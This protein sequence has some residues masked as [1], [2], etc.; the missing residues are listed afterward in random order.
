VSLL[1]PQAG[2]RDGLDD[3]DH[4]RVGAETLREHGKAIL[5]DA[6]T[7]ATG[8]P[9]DDVRVVAE[10]EG[11]VHRNRMRTAAAAS[12]VRSMADHRRRA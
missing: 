11:R 1:V 12:R 9:D 4:E 3:I 7:I 10:A 5:A 6:W 8:E 2:R